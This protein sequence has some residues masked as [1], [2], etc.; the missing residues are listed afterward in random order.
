MN[1]DIL[2]ILEDKLVVVL[3][4]GLLIV[5]IKYWGEFEEWLKKIMDEVCVVNNIILVIDEVYI[6]IG[7]GV[8]E[9][10]IDV[11]NI[12]KLVFLWGEF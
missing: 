5:G 9:G 11:V 6:L 7:V 3:D 8:V 10:V 1:N 12:L 2:D 4:I